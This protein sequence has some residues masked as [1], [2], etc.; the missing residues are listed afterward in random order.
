MNWEGTFDPIK[1]KNKKI[2]VCKEFILVK[3]KNL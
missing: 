2:N 3:K 1:L